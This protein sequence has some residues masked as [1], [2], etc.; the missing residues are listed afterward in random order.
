MAPQP[1]ARRVRPGGHVGQPRRP[2][3]RQPAKDPGTEPVINPEPRRVLG[4]QERAGDDRGPQDQPRRGADGERVRQRR[5]RAGRAA[6]TAGLAD[7]RARPQA[8]PTVPGGRAA[9]VLAQCTALPSGI[10][11]CARSQLS[12]TW[13]GSCPRFHQRIQSAQREGVQA[14]R[15]AVEH[16]NQARAVTRDDIPGQ[17]RRHIL[18]LVAGRDRRPAPPGAAPGCSDPC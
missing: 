12:A 15:H 10:S 4:R 5:R 17:Q 3:P 16:G 9:D 2:H 18:G 14:G 1:G 6:L 11:P 8:G 7:G 13:R